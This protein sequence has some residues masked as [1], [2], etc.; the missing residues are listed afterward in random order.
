MLL[1]LAAIAALAVGRAR[2]GA[3]MAKQSVGKASAVRI[4]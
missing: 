2:A 3:Q 4:L 1:N